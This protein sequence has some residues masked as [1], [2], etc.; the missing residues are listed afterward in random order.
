MK[1]FKKI[2]LLSLLVI[3]LLFTGRTEKVSATI[4]PDYN[5]S[6]ISIE[7]TDDG[8]D[9]KSITFDYLYRETLST[10]TQYMADNIIFIESEALAKQTNLDA[11]NI[12]ANDTSCWKKW[13]APLGDGIYSNDAA[14][15]Q[16]Y[17]NLGANPVITGKIRFTDQ[18]VFS[19][20]D[21]NKTYY[22]CLVFS[23]GQS[24]NN[25][26]PIYFAGTMYTGFYVTINFSKIPSGL[27][28][29]MPS[30]AG[31]SDGVIRGTDTTME[32]ST[33]NGTTWTDVPGTSITGLE[34]GPVLV[35]YKG[36]G[37]TTDNLPVTVNIPSKPVE[38]RPD[39]TS[40]YVPTKI[41]NGDFHEAPWM[42]FT[43]QSNGKTYLNNG[44]DFPIK[45]TGCGRVTAW[46]P[47]GV[48]GGWNTTDSAT[49]IAAGL[50]FNLMSNVP[51]AVE[52][53]G[54]WRV[55]ECLMPDDEEYSFIDLNGSVAAVQYQ[56]LSTYGGDVIRWS[57]DHGVIH[58]TDRTGTNWNN[59]VEAVQDM[60]VE[61]GA[62][63]RDAQDNIVAAHGQNTALYPE[64]EATSRAVY[65][66]T[67]VTN[68]S[69]NAGYGNISELKNLSLQRDT[70]YQK[71]YQ[72][73]G[74][75]IIPEGQSVTRFAFMSDDTTFTSLGNL[76][77]NVKF[78]TLI[79][80]LKA[81]LNDDDSV[82]V[83][84]Y[85]GET[86]ADKKLICR[87]GDKEYAIDTSAIMNGD[88]K[89]FKFTISSSQIGSADRVSIYHEDYPAAAKTVV[90]EHKHIWSFDVENDDNQATIAA[91]CTN[92]KKQNYCSYKDDAITFTMTAANS[93]YAEGVSNQ[94]VII[95]AELQQFN[96]ATGSSI[97][98]EDVIYYCADGV[99]KTTPGNSGAAKEGGAP[100]MPGT[101]C[102]TLKV[103]GKYARAWFKIK[104]SA[105][106]DDDID[107]PVINDDVLDKKH[108]HVWTV[109]LEDKKM[110]ITCLTEKD[111]KCICFDKPVTLTL[112][113]KNNEP[114]TAGYA[115]V[116]KEGEGASLIP[117][118]QLLYKGT[119]GALSLKEGVDPAA[120]TPDDY[121][122]SNG[123]SYEDYSTAP[124]SEGI[125]TAT[126][127]FLDYDIS[128][129]F[130][131][132]N[133]ASVLMI[134]E[135]YCYRYPGKGINRG[136]GFID[137]TPREDILNYAYDGDTNEMI[138]DIYINM[139]QEK[140][141][142]S[143]SY[144]CYSI[145]AGKK[146]VKGKLEDAKLSKAF[147]KTTNIR[148]AT[149]YDDKTKKPAEGAKQYYFNTINKRAAITGLKP[150]YQLYMDPYGITTGQWT[151]LK[152]TTEV[153][154]YQY[155]EIGVASGKKI[156]KAGY[157]IWPATGGVWVAGLDKN[158]K[159]VKETYF[160]RVR[161]TIDT[162]A[163]KVK[164]VKVSGVLKPT[165]L[166]ADY[167]K[168]IL[169][170]KKGVC[171]FFGDEI[172]D[173][174]ER[175]YDFE[176]NLYLGTEETAAAMDGKFLKSATDEQAKGIKLDKY[177]TADRNSIKIW[178]NA[179]K[180]K[181][182]TAV[183]NLVLAA[184]GVISAEKKLKCEK[185]SVILEKGKDISYEFYDETAQKWI[186][187]IP[188]VDATT[189]LKCRIKC[190]VKG[191]KENGK[192]YAKGI[193]A[194][195]V[196]TWGVW[197]TKSEKEGIVS[198]VISPAD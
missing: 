69:K 1:H 162:P 195:C 158:G 47:N 105:S 106:E 119:K 33:D 43:Y 35:R 89:N 19:R 95:S 185:G 48:D 153:N 122:V 116:T 20:L 84:G 13:D 70:Q 101:Y 156:G 31:G 123:T 108:E 40:T 66:S 146:W 76:M 130:C 133:D 194:K 137:Y 174:Y 138:E 63:N 147:N 91:L 11:T 90:L 129:N 97:S 29:Q 117:P 170:L 54:P 46:F 180:S 177:L 60:H 118:Y 186:A 86:D 26:S 17:I 28:A 187:S 192:N 3:S 56:D 58:G 16:G 165:K 182:A 113:L 111:Y 23:W 30:T 100:V 152:V 143:I 85:W 184:R 2:G 128:V 71:W 131:I 107:I 9:L 93:T 166:K 172:P 167:K 37:T 21:K 148:L 73:R 120:A 61:I 88:C 41:I 74:V 45:N 36:S 139:T 161:A 191:G 42:G 171:L 190:N 94:V 57:L 189:T 59:S 49:Q 78:D 114:A 65:T 34:S 104:E 22:A 135:R 150:D 98:K 169:K 144:D 127:I 82:T 164:K 50:L 24:A 99:T 5:A 27:T 112:N 4:V 81:S 80:N 188:K 157:G 155:Y 44:V 51:G 178:M 38:A 18:D 110:I 196:L 142:S 126:L 6:K 109:K 10:A 136:N 154:L 134:K 8:R 102:G 79:G 68:G 176:N 181:P 197:D 62:P 25:Q 14:V 15:D 125:Y 124:N 72:V 179:S 159:P 92:T 83:S 121:I 193:E 64:L 75:Y 39:T 55:N 32:Y 52:Y 145:D 160:Y 87:I 132:Q 141:V 163:S 67:G 149:K 103:D 115:Y 7:Y 183:Q 175:E 96:Q 53:S 198:A 168:E 173:L 140:L 77:S 12:Y 151:L